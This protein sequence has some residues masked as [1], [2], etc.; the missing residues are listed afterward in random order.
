MPALKY[1]TLSV[2]VHLHNNSDSHS[3]AT[4]PASTISDGGPSGSRDPPKRP[5]PRPRPPPPENPPRPK[6]DDDRPPPPPPNRP[7][8]LRPPRPPEKLLPRP[9]IARK[10]SLRTTTTKK[11]LKLGTTRRAPSKRE[12]LFACLLGGSTKNLTTCDP[13]EGKVGLPVVPVPGSYRYKVNNNLLGF[14]F[15]AGHR[16]TNF[17]QHNVDKLYYGLGC[18]IHRMLYFN[19]YCI[20]RGFVIFPSR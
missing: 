8:G 5:P 4:C 1:G 17:P 13:V 12:W 3:C 20:G 15:W 2:N 10:C 16:P 6:D 18:I 7:P 19:M 9:D 11:K 14:R